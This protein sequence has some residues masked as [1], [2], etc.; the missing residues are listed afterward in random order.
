MTATSPATDTAASAPAQ[1]GFWRSSR[2]RY[3]MPVAF[4]TYSL[5]YLDKSNYAIASAGGMAE[6]LR[7]SAGRTP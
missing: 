3:L 6:D 1:T 7:L 2:A 4:V 5:A